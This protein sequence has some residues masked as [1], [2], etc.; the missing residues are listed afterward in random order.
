MALYTE[1]VRSVVCDD[2]GSSYTDSSRQ[3]APFL[4][5]VR[6]DGWSVGREYSPCYCPSCARK[7]FGDR[8]RC[9]GHLEIPMEAEQ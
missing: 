2:C 7:H 3:M 6:E 8:K 5:I 9:G 4:K 1:Y